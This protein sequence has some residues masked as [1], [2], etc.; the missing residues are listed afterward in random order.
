[1]DKPNDIPI[2]I[3]SAACLAANAYLAN[4]QNIA[5]HFARAMMGTQAQWKH[6]N[7]APLVGGT[8]L[9]GGWTSGAP[10]QFHRF[11]VMFRI[12]TDGPEWSCI[13]PHEDGYY[14]MQFW[15]E[16]IPPIPP[17]RDMTVADF[18]TPVQPTGPDSDPDILRAEDD[19][20]GLA[21]RG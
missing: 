21:P 11:W 2:R 16:G 14:P 3:W 7:D 8:Y 13:Y 5:T 9:C 18:V 17:Y 10:P 1:M 12:T 6:T 19:G 4:G 20:M 15:L